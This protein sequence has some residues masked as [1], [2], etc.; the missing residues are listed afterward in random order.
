[1]DFVQKFCHELGT[2]DDCAATLAYFKMYD[3]VCKTV[4][5]GEKLMCECRNGKMYVKHEVI[6]FP[7]LRPF[8]DVGF[9]IK[10]EQEDALKDTMRK[11]IS[12]NAIDQMIKALKKPKCPEFDEFTNEIYDSLM[13]TGDKAELCGTGTVWNGSK[14]V[15]DTTKICGE[16]SWDGS[17]CI[18]TPCT[19]VP[20]DQPTFVPTDQPTFVPTDQPTFTPTDQPT[21]TPTDQSTY[22]RNPVSWQRSYTAGYVDSVSGRYA[23]GSEVLHLVAHDGSLYLANGCWMDT[24]NKAYNPSLKNWKDCWAQVL[25]LD[26]SQGSWAVELEFGIGAMRTELLK[27]VVLSTDAA[28]DPLQVPH[29][30]LIAGVFRVVSGIVSVEL[31]VGVATDGSSD[32]SALEWSETIFLVDPRPENG[33]YPSG[34][35]Y[36][37]RD[38]QVH[39]DVI[40]GVDMLFV[41]VGM[42]GLYVGVYDEAAPGRIRFSATSE[43][44]EV[45]MRIMGIAAADGALFF[46]SGNLIYRRA[47]GA[48][49]TWS[50]VHEQSGV[51]TNHAIGGI[52]GLSSIDNPRDPAQSS[53]IFQAG[54]LLLIF[55]IDFDQSADGAMEQEV[56]LAS[57][58]DDYLG[59]APPNN[60]RYMIGAYNQFVP[61]QADNTTVWLVGFQA[62]MGIVTTTPTLPFPTTAMGT[63]R[64]ASDQYYSGAPFAIRRGPQTYE[65]NEVGGRFYDTNTSLKPLVS[66]RTFAASPFDPES[67]TVF[68]GGFDCNFGPNISDTAWVYRAVPI[69]AL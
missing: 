25:R 37:I 28:G 21:F 6:G 57:M 20:T 12:S 63:R 11:F 69:G 46:S 15:V 30:A 58:F 41:S 51:S 39:R 34:Q 55:R 48:S 54:D 10:P 1:M 59:V 61:V 44:G 50:V 19:S 4:G 14:C 22:F 3:G 24:R 47:D 40:T 56:C 68:F 35:L 23:G 17:T 65:I 7:D 43:T 53:L 5:N 31:R 2:A 9:F 38:C 33:T 26:S 60:A 42:K 8:Y 62:R 32:G 13:L 67:E 27:S 18:G 29:K 64:P 66:T 45:A 52:R 49:P 16:G 36:S